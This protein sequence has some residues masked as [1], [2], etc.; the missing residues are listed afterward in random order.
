VSDLLTADRLATTAEVLTKR[1]ELRSLAERY[2][3]EVVALIDDGTLIVPNAGPSYRQIA[4]L[5]GEAS[6]LV[7]AYVQIITDDVP[8]ASVPTR[9]L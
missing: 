7:G 4:R 9:P 3:F 6:R 8:A 1:A 2:G 5:A